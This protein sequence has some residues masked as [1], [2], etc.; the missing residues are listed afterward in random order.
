MTWETTSLK[1]AILTLNM[2]AGPG[3]NSVNRFYR[4]T[5]L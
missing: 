1:K 2:S 4:P 5:V 3:L